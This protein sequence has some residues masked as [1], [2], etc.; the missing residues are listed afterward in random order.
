MRKLFDVVNIFNY[1]SAK[2]LQKCLLKIGCF[3]TIFDCL[4]F[5]YFLNLISDIPDWFC[6]KIKSN[7]RSFPVFFFV[8]SFFDEEL[9]IFTSFSLR[10]FYN[11]WLAMNE[12]DSK[13]RKTCL[14]KTGTYRNV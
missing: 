1:V 10:L 13:N 2:V 9:F 7:L 5:P 12:C 4:R 6:K 3:K 8:G 11:D 14:N